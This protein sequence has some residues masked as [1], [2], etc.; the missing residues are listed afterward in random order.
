MVGRRVAAVVLHHVQ[1]RGINYASILPV[2]ATGNLLLRKARP[3]AG[4]RYYLAK[5][6]HAFRSAPCTITTSSLSHQRISRSSAS[7]RPPVGNTG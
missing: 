7:V 6:L 2:Q 1:V 3:F 5:A 4:L